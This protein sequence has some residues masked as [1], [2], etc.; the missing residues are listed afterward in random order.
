MIDLHLHIDGSFRPQ[1]IFELAKEMNIDLPADSVEGLLPYIQVPEDCHSL[2][3]YLE[4]FTIPLQVMRTPQ[5][6]ERVTYELIID[7]AAQGVDQAE[8]R[9]A[10]Q[11]CAVT[12]SQKEIVE[13]AIRGLNRG[14]QETKI[15]AGLILCA[16]RG[17]DFETNMETLLLVKEYL[18][19]GVIAFDIAGAE[20]VFKT[21]LYA[22]L[23]AKAREFNIP[24]TI[25]AGEGD[26]PESIRTA[27]DFR[28]K[29]LG[30]GIRVYEDPELMKR[31]RDEKIV[32]EICPISNM[33]TKVVDDP[34]NYPLRQLFDYGILVTINTDNMTMSNTNLQK[35]FAFIKKHYHFTDEEIN[36]MKENAYRASFIK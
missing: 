9:F 16:M 5:A 7:L 17:S 23:F 27:L 18:G 1:T 36:Q 32:L 14:I 33:H 21:H 24:F 22:D 12:T 25:H 19:K 3:E 30:H 2:E 20:I 28:A 13:A 26:G 8:L 6:I 15:K 29:R 4:R 10:P 31:V 11:F 34:A 35:E